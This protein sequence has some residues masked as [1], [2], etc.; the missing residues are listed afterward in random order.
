VIV[1]GLDPSLR[2][3]GMALAHPGTK[4]IA[5]RCLRPKTTGHQRL[6][7]LVRG[8]MDWCT[9]A[10]SAPCDLVVIEGI[11]MGKV[12]GNSILDLAGLGTM[13]RH[14]LWRLGI[15]YAL[16]GP[17]TLKLYATGNGHAD[18]AA[19]M[20]AAYRLLP[21]VTTRTHDEAD[22]VWLA[23]AGCRYYG[24]PLCQLP[25][26]QDAVLSSLCAKGKRKGLPLITWPM[27]GA[28]RP[29][30]GALPGFTPVGLGVAG[31]GVQR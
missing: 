26:R 6:D 11:I 21:Q 27:L 5:T 18:K 13:I 9:T 4:Q 28:T 2:S 8:A 29:V 12:Q 14:E 23:E 16:I 17:T 1:A 19:M 30:Q 22:A 25:L 3:F 31:R 24:H 7:Y 20:A 10:A 15:P